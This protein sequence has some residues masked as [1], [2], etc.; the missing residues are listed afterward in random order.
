MHTEHFV[1]NRN[2][3]KNLIDNFGNITV[4]GTTSVRSLES[5]F[6]IACKVYYNPENITCEFQISQW[7]AYDESIESLK[8]RKLEILKHLYNWMQ[9]NKIKQLNC[10]TQIMIVPGY[11]FVF[12]NRLITNFH[13]PKSTLL[14]LLAAF[15]G[16]KEWPKAYKFA[17]DNEFRF[18]SYGDSCLFLNK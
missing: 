10:S 13:Q 8:D 2:N 1:I 12:T 17:L 5:L 11:K 16:E 15:I 14:L 4:V 6:V 3:I 7:G 9:E 18:L